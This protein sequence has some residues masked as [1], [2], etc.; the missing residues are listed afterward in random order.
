M[1]INA[2]F[3][4]DPLLCKIKIV[5]ILRFLNKLNLRINAFF[6]KIFLSYIATKLNSIFTNENIFT[7]YFTSVI[8]EWI[9]SWDKN[10]NLVEFFYITIQRKRNI[11][12]IYAY[13]LVKSRVLRHICFKHFSVSHYIP[14]KEKQIF[15]EKVPKSQ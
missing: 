2:F 1:R 4:K 9:T 6:C 5:L 10:V 14:L 12:K 13:T 8:Y 3:C 11:F 7:Y 15:C